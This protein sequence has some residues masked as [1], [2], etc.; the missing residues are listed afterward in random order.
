MNHEKKN[1]ILLKQKRKNKKENIREKKY[2]SKI[3]PNIIQ[4]TKRPR[5]TIFILQK[6][7]KNN[8]KKIMVL[9]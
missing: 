1:S 4:R 7:I 3:T 9:K 5:E 8:L 6:H 2:G